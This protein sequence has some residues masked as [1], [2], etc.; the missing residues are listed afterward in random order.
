[1]QHNIIRSTKNESSS[2]LYIFKVNQIKVEA[3][4]LYIYI[5]IERERERERE[6]VAS[7]PCNAQKKLTK[8][9]F[10]YL[11]Y[12]FFCLI[13]KFDNMVIIIRYLLFILF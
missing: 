4:Q 7:N 1:M 11:F 2:I 6:R 12:L 3:L 8:F 5:Y 9:N 10:F 13:M